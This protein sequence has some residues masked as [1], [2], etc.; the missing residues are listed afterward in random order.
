VFQNIDVTAGLTYQV[1]GWLAVDSSKSDARLSLQWR[2]NNGMISSVGVG[3][4]ATGTVGWTEKSAV[5]KAP[6]GATRARLHLVL[7][8]ESD[9]IGSAWFDELS[10]VRSN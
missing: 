2:T 10:L 3:G 8:K 4:V 5:I 1:E 6:S 9:G 7:E